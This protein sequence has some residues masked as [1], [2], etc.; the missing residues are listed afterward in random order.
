MAAMEKGYW[1][2]LNN[3]TILPDVR[4]RV[5]TYDVGL[6]SQW[7]LPVSAERKDAQWTQWRTLLGGV[8]LGTWAITETG[9]LTEGILEED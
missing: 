8:G 4:S 7:P 9:S 1:K 5:E 6:F 3:R 2:I